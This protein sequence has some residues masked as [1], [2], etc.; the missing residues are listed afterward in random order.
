MR[1]REGAPSMAVTASSLVQRLIQHAVR[2]RNPTKARCGRPPDASP[3]SAILQHL[4]AGDI[5]AAIDVL[6]RSPSRFP[7]Y[8]YSGLLQLCASRR[9]LVAVRRIESH[10][11][12][13]CDPST[14]STFLLNRTIETYGRCGGIA[15]ALELF[16][17]MP[18]RNGGTWNA[19][20]SACSGAGCAADA[21]FLF[22]RM[23]CSGIRPNAVT[24]A[25][26]LGSCANLLALMLAK[27]VHGLILKFGFC[28]NVILGTS[29]VDV[30]GKCW[31]MDEAQKMFDEI[32]N[33]NPVSW[34]VIVRRYLDLNMR[35]E[36]LVM[37][38][39]MIRVGVRPMSFTVSSALIACSDVSRLKAGCQIHG[40]VVKC[41]Y[42]RDSII[43]SSLVEMYVKCGFLEYA[44]C[45]FNYSVSRDVVSWTSML[46]GYV[47]CGRIY[48]AEFLFYEMPERNVVSWNSLLSGYVQSNCWDKAFEFF[49]EMLSEAEEI[50]V[51]TLGLMLNACSGLLDIEKGKQIHGFAY[52]NFCHHMLLFNNALLDMY[53]KCGNLKSSK[54]LFILMGC[55]RDTVSW[56]SLLTGYARHGR[57][58]EAFNIFSLMLRENTPNEFTF[59]VMLSASPNIFMLDQGK[60]MH[61]YMIRNSIKIDVV[62]R[63]ALVDVYCKCGLL[64][65][66]LRVFN[67]CSVRDIVLWN[68]LI[69]GCAYLGRGDYSIELFQEMQKDGI[70]AD[71]ITFMGILHACIGAGFVSLGR[72]YFERMVSEYGVMPRLE[73]YQCMIEQLCKHGFLVELEEFIE[74]MPFEPT[75]PMWTKIYEYCTRHRYE[76][77]GEVASSR[78][79]HSF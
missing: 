13:S 70:R 14:P 11:I 57:S 71:D 29:L 50:D 30:Y 4:A 25:S 17:E 26:V 38:S 54:V 8:V 47:S 28:V 59:S 53:A 60:Q 45:V 19:V 48:E 42:G 73:H 37:F 12:S 1:E 66:A 74:Q 67:E 15:D 22:A 43:E 78:I 72:W 41:G 35:E 2:P 69:L 16:D 76:R 3:H 5:R 31:I 10:I 49:N 23:H 9:A 7:P 32:S 20:I 52:R 44:Q 64:D 63:A 58:E 75:I 51:V 39:K 21:V 79:S 46:S 68:S 18:R 65:Y 24:F 27:Q 61:G 56:N 62:I 33:P 34:N 36:A 77:L 40:V 55:K 6:S